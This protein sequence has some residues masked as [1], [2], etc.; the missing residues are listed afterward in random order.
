MGGDFAPKAAVEGARRAA[1]AEDV[2]VTLVGTERARGE[3][4]ADPRIRWE[5]ATEVIEMS[6]SPVAGA[7]RKKDS[8]MA[9]CARLVQAGKADAWVS[10]GNSGAITAVSMFVHGRLAGVMRPAFGAVLPTLSGARSYLIDCGA[11]VDCRAEMLAEF[12]QMGCVYS[13]AILGVP[14]PRVALLSNGIE[15]EKGTK[16]TRAAAEL[17]KHSGLRFV[18]SVEGNDLFA[19]KA[20]VIVADGFVANV[21]MKTA[22][23]MIE[24]AGQAVR[25]DIRRNIVSTIGGLLILPSVRRLRAGFDWRR[26]GGA[27]VLGVDGVVVVAHGRSD[28]IA[29]EHAVLAAAQA[30]RVRLIDRLREAFATGR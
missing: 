17:L 24:L 28:P 14:E 6:E 22:E 30:V 21:A 3:A 13:S 26:I 4:G 18:G 11:S 1:Y 8:S 2:E 23:A 20:D 15:P 29:I 10:A 5:L 19:G 9:V 7:R 25:K 12:A 16:E 27:P